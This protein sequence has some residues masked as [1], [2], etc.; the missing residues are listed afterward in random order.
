MRRP[1]RKRSKSSDDLEEIEMDAE[2]ML[3]KFKAA[4]K[5]VEEQLGLSGEFNED[6]LK[7]HV[8]S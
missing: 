6:E 1:E 3:E 7:Y 2:D 8:S 4:R 5:K